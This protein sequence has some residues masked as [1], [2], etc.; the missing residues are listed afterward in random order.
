MAGSQTYGP[1]RIVSRDMSFGKRLKAARLEVGKTQQD[2]GNIF[3]VEREAVAQWE[4]DAVMPTSDKLPR[5][6]RAL[7]K[8][9][10]YLLTGKNHNAVT[11]VESTPDEDQLRRAGD[12]KKFANVHLGPEIARLVPLISWV[13]AGKF[14]E[15]VDTLPPGE[16]LDWMPLPRRAGPRTYALRVE[17]DSMSA[18]FGRSYPSGCVIFVDP[19]KRSPASG[20]R[21]IAKLEGGDEV[22]FKQFVQEAGK[23]FLRPLNPQYPPIFE[24]FKVIGTVIGKWED[25]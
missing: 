4:A 20:Q 24:A 11:D 2:I 16:A 10:D 5:L 15:A 12:H 22:T 13:V 8:T 9:I 1:P 25:D 21:V 14:S 3:G 23:M 17:G 18:P 6:A 7:R 19:D